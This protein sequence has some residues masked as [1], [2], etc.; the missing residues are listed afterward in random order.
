MTLPL[1]EP[2]DL[3]DM[4]P[5]QAVDAVTADMH[6]HKI[7]ADPTGVFHAS[8][9]TALLSHVTAQLAAAV[10]YQLTPNAFGLP[11]AAV[12]AQAATHLGRA[13]AHHCQALEQV[14]TLATSAQDTLPQQVAALGQHRALGVHLSNAHA[15]LTEA[16]LL[17]HAPPTPAAPD[18]HQPSRSTGIAP[19]PPVAGV[20]PAGG[21]HTRR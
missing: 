18:A 19:A 2:V 7:T 16:R 11:P 9:H 13:V 5:R 14:V 20:R 4:L 21:E 10:E 17:L 3:E 6:E 15:A 12:L 8:R 1:Y